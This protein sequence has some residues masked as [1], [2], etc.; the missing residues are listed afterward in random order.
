MAA[1]L[2]FIRRAISAWETRAF[3]LLELPGENALDRQRSR[4]LQTTLLAQES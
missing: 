3:R 4:F 1:R 2:A